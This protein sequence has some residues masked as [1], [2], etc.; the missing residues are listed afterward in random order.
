MSRTRKPADKL[1]GAQEQA[2]RRRTL[3][4]WPLRRTATEAGVSHET[5]CRWQSL[6]AWIEYQERIR[7]EMH[8]ATVGSH[9]AAAAKGSE[10]RTR[11]LRQIERILEIAESSD[12]TDTLLS[13]SAI[14]DI[15]ATLDRLATSA[16]DRA[17]Y[18]RTERREVAITAETS[19][20]D[21]T[22]DELD[23]EEERATGELRLLHGGRD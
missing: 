3:D 19:L 10:L 21:M 4:G 14:K 22:P 1:T 20:A 2:C 16:E 23:A 11:W 9:I 15:G 8:A 17:G 7:E 18:P 12:G 5:V 13:A 6:P